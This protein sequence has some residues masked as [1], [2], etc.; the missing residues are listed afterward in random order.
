MTGKLAA[1]PCL[2][3]PAECALVM[4][5]SRGT[6]LGFAILLVFFR[7]YSR[8]PRDQ[9]E[10]DPQSIKS[11]RKQLKASI[12][13]DCEAFI[14]ERTAERL[15]AEIRAHFGFRE[16][17]VADAENLTSWLRDKL[18]EQVDSAIEL[19]IGR[20]ETRC[21][22]LRI[23]PPTTERLE[24]IAR[25]A[26]R[27]HEEKL[28]ADIHARLSAATCERLDA[29][30]RPDKS[31]VSEET[32][33]SHVP[34]QLLT[35]LASPGK[36]SLASL[37]DELAKLTLI[38]SIQLPVNLFD[39]VSPRDLQRC[40]RRVSVESPH[41]LRRHPDAA[42]LTWLAAFVYLQARSLTDGL[43]DLLIETIHMIGARAERKVEKELL[44]DLKHVSGKQN[45]LFELAEAALN[46]PD[47]LVREVVFPVIGKQTSSDN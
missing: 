1:V 45:L 26:L 21:R 13:M 29:L 38:R 30:L 40:R 10:I 11:L 31:A 8:F 25:S 37:Q 46:K 24:R 32:P 34:A 2:L 4:D 15:R 43:V 35:L 9:A 18:A 7:E 20:L 39:R 3:T 28:H 23:E 5:K 42:R 6:R 17:S 33:T 36:P 41:E 27:A 12:T 22:E 16:A 44:E 47:G 19:M 14:T